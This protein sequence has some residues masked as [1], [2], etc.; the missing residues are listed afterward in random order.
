MRDPRRAVFRDGAQTPYTEWSAY[1]STPL[2]DRGPLEALQE[3]IRI[4]GQRWFKRDHNGSVKEFVCQYPVTYFRFNAH[5]P[6]EG[7][8]RYEADTLFRVF[9]LKE[10]HGREHETALVD[11]AETT[12]HSPTIPAVFNF[13]LLSFS[14][15]GCRCTHGALCPISTLARP[16]S[17]HRRDG[18]GGALGPP[19]RRPELTPVTG[20]PFVTGE[21]NVRRDDH[22]IRRSKPHRMAL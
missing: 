8:T 13:Q 17:R 5:D 2:Y 9:V 18:A 10:L 16:R 6:Y 12:H 7:T 3:D 14:D 21:A 22:E 4:V 15:R 19:G 11:S 1:D 20:V